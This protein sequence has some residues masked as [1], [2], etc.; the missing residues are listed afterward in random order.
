MRDAVFATNLGV[1]DHG[2]R[3]IIGLAGI[4]TWIFGWVSG[5]WAPVLGITGTVLLLTAVFGFC[6]LYRLLG[7]R[8]ASRATAA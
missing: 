2:I 7:I 4:A 6:P 1:G 8:T 5:V 3:A